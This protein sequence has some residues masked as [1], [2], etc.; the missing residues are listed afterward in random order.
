[1][2][3]AEELGNAI[4]QSVEYGAYPEEEAVASAKLPG[5][6]IQTV[7]SLVEKAREDVRVGFHNRAM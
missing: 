1:M 2:P 3:S 4:L 6:A 7:L 5:D